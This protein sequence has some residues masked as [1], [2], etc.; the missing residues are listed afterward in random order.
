MLRGAT[1]T[2]QASLNWGGWMGCGKG[3]GPLC[4][5]L[6]DALR[7]RASLSIVTLQAPS[8]CPFH[9]G[10]PSFTPPCEHR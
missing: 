6:W 1:Q 9:C 4:S 10:A 8:L 5:L 7:P 2:P 3:W